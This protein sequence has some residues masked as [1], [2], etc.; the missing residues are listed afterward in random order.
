MLLGLILR[1]FAAHHP[2]VCAHVGH[3]HLQWDRQQVPAAGVVAPPQSQPPTRE[4]LLELM[5][6]D[7]ILG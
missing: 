4:V 7:L 3:F 6:L 5:I 1:T 2:A